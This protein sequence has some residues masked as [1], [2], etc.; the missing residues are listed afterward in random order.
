MK[1]GGVLS[2]LKLSEQLESNLTE[3]SQRFDDLQ[4]HFE[5]VQSTLD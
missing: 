4:E 3:L 5:L 1:K 2:E